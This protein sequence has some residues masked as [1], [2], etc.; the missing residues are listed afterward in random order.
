[1]ERKRFS[2]LENAL[3]LMNTFSVEKPEYN[4][5]ELAEKLSIAPSTV[6][7]LLTTLR[8]D[9]FVVKDTL[10]KKYR[11][12]ISIRALESTIRKEMDLFHLSQDILEEIVLRTNLSASLA[13]IFQEAAFYLNAIEVDN[14]LFS[15]F[16][17]IGKQS[18]FLSTSAGKVLLVSKNDTDIM[19]LIKDPSIVSKLRYELQT[20]GYIQSNDDHHIGITTIAVPIKNKQNET[21]AALEMIGTKTQIQN[22][23]QT[24]KEASVKLSNKVNNQ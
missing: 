17:Y 23:V 11:L 15:K 21:L 19:T 7:R 16:C 4:L 1:M 12:G 2:S 13:I 8:S 10:S 5:N 9:G 6:H 20:N 14:P 18:P 3:R 22:N 24:I